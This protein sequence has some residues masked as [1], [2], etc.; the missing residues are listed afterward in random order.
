MSS[1]LAEAIQKGRPWLDQFTRREYEKAFRSYVQVY[2]SPCH[3]EITKA[4]DALPALAESVLDELEEGRKRIRFWNR[5]TQ[6][7]DEQQT[8]IKY[9]TPMLLE[10]GDTA[11]ADCLHDAWCR[12][13][14]KYAYEQASFE[15]LR[16]GFVNVIL[17]ITMRDKD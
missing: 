4:A 2:G 8:V 7:F 17:G 10:Q 3:G 1:V 13:W 15:Q 5:S 16:K 14:T 9:F 11:F 6:V 12:R